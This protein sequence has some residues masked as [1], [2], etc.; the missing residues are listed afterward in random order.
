MPLTLKPWKVSAVIAMLLVTSVVV[1]LVARKR[2]AMPDLIDRTTYN[3]PERLSDLLGSP[4]KIERLQVG[5]N[6]GLARY[7]LHA[8]DLR[9]IPST[10]TVDIYVWRSRCRIPLDRTCVV[11]AINPQ[12]RDVL[13]LTVQSWWI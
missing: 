10:G 6:K 12:T 1:A 13:S 7:S 5:D 11:A 3:S 9:G 2:C 4:W 8:S